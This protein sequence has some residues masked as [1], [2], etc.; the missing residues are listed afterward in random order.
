M[1]EELMDIYD[2]NKNLTGRTIYRKGRNILNEDEYVIT[3]H[4]FII[5]SSGQ[6]LLTQRSLNT[7]RGGKWED[8]HGGVRAKETSIEGIIREL[9]EEIGINVTQSELKLVKTIKKKN[10]F[11]DVY[12]LKRDI[13]L[14]DF[15]LD[16]NEVMDCKYVTIDEFKEMI[17][18]G[19]CT[20]TS[21]EQTIFYDN[22]INF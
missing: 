19:E 21:F 12:I 14:E 7:D 9:K 17:E 2:A 3:S 15:V 1:D 11:R 8:T 13:P 6:I 18:K 22:N 10:V 20:F 16:K 4:C 5:N